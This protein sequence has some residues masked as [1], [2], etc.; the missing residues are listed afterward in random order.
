M[1]KNAHGH[2]AVATTK[3][4]NRPAKI[5]VEASKALSLLA[6]ENDFLQL[7]RLPILRQNQRSAPNFSLAVTNNYIQTENGT[8]GVFGSDRSVFL[9]VFYKLRC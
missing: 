2:D 5:V 6:V 7:I 8:K 9:F 1:R 3:K 4:Q